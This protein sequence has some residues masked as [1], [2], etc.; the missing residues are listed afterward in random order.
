M[1]DRINAYKRVGYFKEKMATAIGVKFTGTIYA[2]DRVLQHIRKRH[3]K[4]LNKKVINNPIEYMKKIIDAPDY[5]G[6]YKSTDNVINIELIKKFNEYILVGIEIDNNKDFINVLT[7]YPITER[8]IY[9]KLYR[10]KI[11]KCI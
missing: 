8:K 11:K 6:V 10:G 7:M 1:A 2:S 9:N 4:H 3:G 5:I